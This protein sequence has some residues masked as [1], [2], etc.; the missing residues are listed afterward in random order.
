VD[1]KVWAALKELR[2]NSL[3]DE[4]EM[5]ILF[6][7]MQYLNHECG[8]DLSLKFNAR[9]TAFPNFKGIPLIVNGYEL[10][11]EY[12][13]MRKELGLK[14]PL[15]KNQEVLIRYAIRANALFNG[16]KCLCIKCAGQSW[17]QTDVQ[18]GY[19]KKPKI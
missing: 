6:G 14:R 17:K 12:D 13:G 18:D 7:P 5:H 15:R 1:E 8:A 2:Y 10:F 3:V 19:N 4:D 11:D 16:A 9:V